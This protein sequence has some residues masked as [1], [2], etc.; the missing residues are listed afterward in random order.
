MYDENMEFNPDI[1]N[2]DDIP[3]EEEFVPYEPP[4]LPIEEIHMYAQVNLETGM[5][6]VISYIA[7]D[8]YNES[9]ILVPDDFDPI[10][11]K[12]VDGEWVEYIP[13]PDPDIPTPK[14]NAELEAENNRLKAQIS[15]LSDQLD[16]QEECIVEMAS[17]IYA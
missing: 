8:V 7:G 11:K 3:V 9:L 1:E 6:E 14:T 17:I 13:D 15:A 10:N 2:I 4:V 12:Y 16:F 5:I